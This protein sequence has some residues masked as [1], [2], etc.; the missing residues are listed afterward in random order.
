MT[1]TTKISSFMT[2]FF[3]KSMGDRRANEGIAFVSPCQH[4]QISPRAVLCGIRGTD[5]AIVA[6]KR[7]GPRTRT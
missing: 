5:D 2:I 6:R 1:T 4:K 7:A 3:G